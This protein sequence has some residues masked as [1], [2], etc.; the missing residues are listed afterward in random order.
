MMLDENERFETL[1]IIEKIKILNARQAA[2]WRSAHG[3][4]PDNAA[5]LLSES[6][7]DWQ[8]SLTDC[9]GLWTQHD[10]LSDGELIL[11]WTNLGA[12]V[13]G[14]MKLFFSIYYNDYLN[15]PQKD[16][17]DRVINPDRMEFETSR[18]TSKRRISCPMK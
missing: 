16:R 14:T 3:W 9:L 1:A 13:E 5:D 2:F 7:L 12:L 6:R 4:A 18:Y 15:D 11:A 10:Q 17:K 8:V